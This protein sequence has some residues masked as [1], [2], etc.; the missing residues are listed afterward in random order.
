M[1]SLSVKAKDATTGADITDVS[2]VAQIWIKDE[3]RVHHYAENVL[4]AAAEKSGK[5]IRV[6]YVQ[7]RES[8]IK[9]FARQAWFVRSPDGEL[10]AILLKDRTEKWS[11]HHGGRVLDYAGARDAV[12]AIR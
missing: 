5:R 11:K 7:D 8:G 12:I 2:W 6:V 1:A 3:P 4:R 9:L 10:S